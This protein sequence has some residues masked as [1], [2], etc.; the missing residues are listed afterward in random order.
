[1][2]TIH[3]CHLRLFAVIGGD[4]RP[5]GAELRYVCFRPMTYK[6]RQK[7]KKRLKSARR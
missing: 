2:L 7:P 3:F 1:M 6:S 4:L 5:F